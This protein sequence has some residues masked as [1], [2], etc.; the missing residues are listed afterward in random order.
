HESRLPLRRVEIFDLMWCRHKLPP[1][2]APPLPLDRL[3]RGTGVACFRSEWDNP[4]ATYVG[5]K[6]GRNTNGHAHLDVGSFVLDALGERWA[7]DLGPERY[8][9]GGYFSPRRWRY[10][11][12]QN[13]S[14]NTLVLD[15]ELQNPRANAPIVGFLS[16]DDRAHAVADMGE[17]YG[18]EPG[19]VRRGVALLN[20]RDVLVQD[21]LQLEEPTD[22]V[23]NLFTRADVKVDG[24][25]ATLSLRGKQIN[26][27]LLE[28]S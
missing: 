28:P 1:T 25:H 4:E 11:R 12:T 24:R 5:S 27:Q 2:E 20:R 15:D 18:R 9:V 13:H 17:V 7:I 16:T 14:H 19:T 8:E 6:A 26:V 10:F 23:W 22:V 21:D 3:F